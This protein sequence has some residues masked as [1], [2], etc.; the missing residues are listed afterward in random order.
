MLIQS[1]FY[2]ILQWCPGHTPLLG[3]NTIYCYLRPIALGPKR[4]GFLG[5]VIL[6]ATV[7]ISLRLQIPSVLAWLGVARRAL[8]RLC[9]RCCESGSYAKQPI[10]RIDT[11]FITTLQDLLDG[12]EALAMKKLKLY[13]LLKPLWPILILWIRIAFV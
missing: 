5:F 11:L 2:K 8:Q 4:F 6:E 9:T 1:C 10:H 12:T 7:N 3:S 13:F